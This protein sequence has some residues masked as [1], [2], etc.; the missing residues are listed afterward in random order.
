MYVM[1][2]HGVT[3]PHHAASQ[4]QLGTPVDKGSLQP[5]DLVFF[6]SP[7]HHVGMYIGGGYFVEA[8]HTGAY[9]QVSPLAGRTDYVGARRYPWRYRVGPP[10]GVSAK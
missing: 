2:Q 10:M 6:G 4:Y 1:A 9:V 7:V 8:P 3:L 5:G